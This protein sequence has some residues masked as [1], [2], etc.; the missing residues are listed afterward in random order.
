M[1]TIIF[2]GGDISRAI[3]SKLDAFEICSKD[4]SI[5]EKM[6]HIVAGST[7]EP[8][9]V[10]VTSGYLL[11][12]SIEQIEKDEIEK[13]ISA[14]LL[15]PMHIWRIVS[16]KIVHN[17]GR[18]IVFS[19]SAVE[20]VRDGYAMYASAKAGLE[21]FICSIKHE[22]ENV[23]TTVIRNART[24]TKMRWMN[25]EKTPETIENLLEPEDVAEAIYDLILGDKKC[26]MLIIYKSRDRIVRLCRDT[27]C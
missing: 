20:P 23:D 16:Q 10:I 15:Y 19:S 9:N 18:F 11:K 27:E 14:N 2:G 24:N 25:Y 1:I 7:D 12:H 4:I 13:H 17:G 22:I 21:R 3:T 6:F 5:A 8:I 26:D